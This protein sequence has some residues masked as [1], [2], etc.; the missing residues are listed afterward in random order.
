MPN[1]KR[2]KFS[3]ALKRIPKDKIG[4]KDIL[5][6]DLADRIGG[7]EDKLKVTIRL[8]LRVINEAKRESEKLGVGYQ[9]I[10]NDRLLEI[11]SLEESTYL[12]GNGTKE[13]E[14]LIK[15]MQAR[16]TK[17]EQQQVKKQA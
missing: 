9:K 12:K 2:E 10:I 14:K 3:K 13:L 6:L 7:L 11:Y 1:P 15:D 4:R 5:S 8:D 16:I 17:L